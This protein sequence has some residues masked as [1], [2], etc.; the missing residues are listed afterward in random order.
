MSLCEEFEEKQ[1]SRAM[2]RKG[3]KK[4]AAA[5]GGEPEPYPM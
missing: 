3:K 1:G 2:V 5:W 4:V